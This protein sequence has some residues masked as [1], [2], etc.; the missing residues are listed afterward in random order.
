MSSFRRSL[1]QTLLLAAGASPALGCGGET[2]DGPSSTGGQG[3]GPSG[4]SGQGGASPA[5]GG[6][7][8]GKTSGSAGTGGSTAGTGGTVSTGGSAGSVLTGG[9]AG[10]KVACESPVVVTVGGDQPTGLVRCANGALLR[11]EATT[12]PNLI[13]PAQGACSFDPGST[14]ESCKINADCKTKPYGSCGQDFDSPCQCQYGCVQDSD[15][16]SDEL[17]QCG[18]PV[19]RCVKANCKTGADC[20]EGGCAQ[21]EAGTP[22]CGTQAFACQQLS[23]QCASNQECQTNGEFGLCHIETPGDPRQCEP[24]VC[25]VG[26]PLVVEHVM[27]QAA[28]VTA[29]GWG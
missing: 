27:R 25:A 23:D 18:P 19:G 13:D 21:H 14:P 5:G 6:G 15:C 11:M 12:C 4:T 2:T 10:A 3:G 16:A 9:S 22:G 28:L 1:L 20:P 24:T 29:G 8:A 7:A 17:C 26:R